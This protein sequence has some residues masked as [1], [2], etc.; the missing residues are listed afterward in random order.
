MASSG[1]N[2][3]VI[4]AGT[5]GYQE[6]ELDEKSNVQILHIANSDRPVTFYTLEVIQGCLQTRIF[7]RIASPQSACQQTGRNIVKYPGLIVD[8]VLN[9]FP[10]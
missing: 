4:R 7:H 8:V 3:G 6:G 1:K 5:V 2:C 9:S 10:H